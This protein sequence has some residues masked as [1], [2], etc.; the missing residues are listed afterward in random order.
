MLVQANGTLYADW[1]NPEPDLS[2]APTT[3]QSKTATGFVLELARAMHEYGTP[4]HRLE[5]ALATV[6]DRLDLTAEFFSTPT[7][8]MVGFGPLVDQQVH[9]LRVEPGETNLGNLAQLGDIVTAV[10]ADEIP[11]DEGL[12]R[13]RVIKLQPRRWPQWL[14]IVAFVLASAAVATFMKVRSGDVLVAA[15]LG[16]ITSAVMLASVARPALRPVVEPLTAFIV[17]TLALA[18]D[19]FLHTGN[20]YPTS[21]AG[22]VVLLPGL[23]FTVALTELSTRHLASGTARLSGAMVVFLGLGFGVAL[24]AKLGGTLGVSLREMWSPD[25]MAWLSRAALPPWTEWAALLIAPLAFTVLLNA[26]ARDASWIVAAC[27]IAYV[28][29]RFVGARMGDELGAFFGA[30]VVS[31]GS[32]LA[33]RQFRRT[34]MVTQVPGLL[35]LV[36]GIIGFRSVTSFFGQQMEAGLETGFRLV[37]IGISLAAGIVAGN[38]LVGASAPIRNRRRVLITPIDVAHP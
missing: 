16:L 21:I 27:V 10:T 5:S 32:N 1:V 34:A 17:T 31:A 35:I 11:V 9:L 3:A 23:T 19:T 12:R 30:L 6:A 8:I 36:P 22:L 15:V 28:S 14:V 18:V 7:S 29:S 20:G 25:S 37:V 33:A 13:I 38:I 2:A 4:A 24:G 26:T